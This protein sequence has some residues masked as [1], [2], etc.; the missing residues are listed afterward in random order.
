MATTV[1]AAVVKEKWEAFPLPPKLPTGGVDDCDT[2]LG[3]GMM[4]SVGGPEDVP[5][6]PPVG[7][8]PVTNPPL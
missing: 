1:P 6:L 8:D 7:K 5:V 4:W 2:V 3:M